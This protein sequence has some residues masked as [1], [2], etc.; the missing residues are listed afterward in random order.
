MTYSISWQLRDIIKW[1]L[2]HIC[3]SINNYNFIQRHLTHF[4]KKEEWKDDFKVYQEWIDSN[5][6]S[7][8]EEDIVRIKTE[9]SQ[10]DEKTYSWLL[11]SR[12]MMMMNWWIWKMWKWKKNCIPVQFTQ[13]TCSVPTGI[14]DECTPTRK[15]IG[16]LKEKMQGDNRLVNT[17]SALHKDNSQVTRVI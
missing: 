6:H 1:T 9:L 13:D 16:A 14:N 5:K 3:I 10:L 12:P 7:V 17:C 11:F 8:S 15:G 4:L 2:Y